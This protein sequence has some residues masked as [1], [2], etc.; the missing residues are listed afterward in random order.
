MLIVEWLVLSLLCVS[1]FGIAALAA[2]VRSLHMAR[3]I[4]SAHLENLQQ[5]IVS[6]QKDLR[7]LA[8]QTAKRP[9]PVVGR[10][11][12]SEAPG[13]TPYAQAIELVR[14][15]LAAVEVAARCGI[16]RSEA[17]L[18]VSLYRNNSPS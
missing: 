13:N 12:P 5:Q 2:W 7:F 3:R 11:A 15:G 18:I 1:M 4:D 17:E 16:S 10:I 8:E 6:L 9:Q 14:Q